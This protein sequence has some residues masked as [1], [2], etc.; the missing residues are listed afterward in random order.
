LDV[1]KYLIIAPSP[2]SGNALCFLTANVRMKEL[3]RCLQ[4]EFGV[5][6][7]IISGGKHEKIYLDECKRPI[8]FPR[9]IRK[10]IP[11]YVLRE[12]CNVLKI[13]KEYLL[14]VCFDMNI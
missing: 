6:V 1:P 13:D 10:G 14:R 5:P 4:R 2:V 11:P 8:T 12:I 7:K 9:G 3:L